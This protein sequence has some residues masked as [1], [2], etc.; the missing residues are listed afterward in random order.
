M[1]YLLPVIFTLCPNFWVLLAMTMFLFKVEGQGDLAALPP[2]PPVPQTHIENTVIAW[3]R[4][5]SFCQNKLLIFKW[6]RSN[7]SKCLC[8]PWIKWQDNTTG[9]EV[10]N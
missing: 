7:L 2:N 9:L 4:Q 3:S 8:I 10:V 1:T 5:N 6:R